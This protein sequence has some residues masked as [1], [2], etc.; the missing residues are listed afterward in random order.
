M[1]SPAE[2]NAMAVTIRTYR[3]GDES[4]QV[5]IYNEAARDLP[6]FKPATVPEIQ[7]RTRARDF[8]P[9]LRF[10]ADEAGTPVGYATVNAHGR[11]G[12]PWCRPG[13]EQAAE[14]LWQAV[15]E[16]L[17]ERGNRKA[18]TAYRA[19]WPAV[20]DFFQK[21]GFRPAREMVNF[22]I[23]VVD[24]PTPPARPS[25]AITP[26]RR[27]DVPG[28]FALVPQAL[29][30]SSAAELEKHLF[31]NPYFPAEAA[32]VLRSRSD[33]TPVAAGILVLDSTY[34]DP[35]QVDAQMPCFRLGAFGTEGMQTKR[36]NGLFSFVARPDNNL[37]PLGLDLLGH[38]AY[39]LRVIED[40]GTLAAQVP[41]DVP[42]LLRF[43]ERNFRRQGSFPVLERELA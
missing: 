7:R 9:S 28:V 36:I 40:L 39:R 20:L 42:H 13:H 21:Q 2:E 19:D 25:S 10:F 15:L 16:T 41:S 26:L 22:V 18:F 6:K 1:E 34:A 35:C 17:R 12:Y 32:F 5:A 3:A 37:S 33:Q 30:V 4:A 38:A 27:E 11:V 31:A 14:P 24:L 23:E 8:D 43:Y 29:R